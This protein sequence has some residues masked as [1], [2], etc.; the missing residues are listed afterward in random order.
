MF[1]AAD[2]P[3]ALRGRPFTVAAAVQAGVPPSRLRGSRFTRI[4][5]GVYIT[6]DTPVTLEHRGAAALLITPPGS[7]LSTQTAVSL[8]GLSLTG[9]DVVHVH[10]PPGAAAP[11]PREGIA[12]HRPV[13]GFGSVPHRGLRLTTPGRTLLDVARA[14]PDDEL[15]VIGDHFARTGPGVR[16]LWCAVENCPRHPQHRRVMRVLGRV[17][18][19][20]DSPQETRLRLVIVRCGLPEPMVDVP[21]RDSAGGWI[22]QAD[23]GYP[24]ARVAIQDEGD[25][26]RSTPRRWR[27]DI[28]RDEA[29]VAVGW[30]VLR[31]TAEDVRRPRT[32]CQRLA[33]ALA[34]AGCDV[35]DA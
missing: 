32:F 33:H 24:R 22:G 13:L 4:V 29:F 19:G 10:V 2:I 15:V 28:A 7:A 5:R 6:S 26:H 30:R 16:S 35:S 17:R 25:V 27:Q 11:R 1:P 3:A 12:V 34:A 14:L 23:L 31:A 18:V 8:R 9:D 21:V 20:V